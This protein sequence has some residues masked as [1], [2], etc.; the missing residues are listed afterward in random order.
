[1]SPD[2]LPPGFDPSKIPLAQPPP[3]MIP[4]FE[5]P[6]SRCWQVYLTAAICSAVVII[7]ITLR[8]YSRIVVTKKQTLD[9]RKFFSHYLMQIILEGARL[10]DDSRSDGLCLCKLSNV[11]VRSYPPA[12]ATFGSQN[13][14][15]VRND[16]RPLFSLLQLLDANTNKVCFFAYCALAISGTYFLNYFP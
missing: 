9:D 11:I 14:D 2:S 12:S 6:E 7:F 5:H 4:N 16:S 8:L 10:T 3:G 13:W 15:S 1:M